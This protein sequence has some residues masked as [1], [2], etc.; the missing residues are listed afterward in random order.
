LTEHGRYSTLF[1]YHGTRLDNL[2]SI[3]YNGFLG[4][5]NKLS[6][7]G[8]GSYFSFEPSVSLHYS[9]F[10]A[11]WPNSLLGKRLSCLLLCEIIDH[12][13]YVKLAVEKGDGEQSRRA[14]SDTQAGEI[15]DKYVVVTNNEHVRVKYIF[16]YSQPNEPPRSKQ[17]S[18]F[19]TFIS[20]NRY[21]FGLLF[22]FILLLLIGLFNSN[23]FTFYFRIL[24]K[25]IKQYT[26]WFTV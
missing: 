22:Y 23:M 16:V 2:H 15:P 21:Y 19:R 13:D 20:T 10:T 18:K 3:L 14:V 8:T 5:Y 25:K 1:A 24:K 7:F 17:T 4:H 26:L 11:V 12:P 6:L 9:P